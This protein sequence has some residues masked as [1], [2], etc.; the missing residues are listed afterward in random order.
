MLVACEY[1]ACDAVSQ[2][3]HVSVE[4]P[5]RHLEG[6]I[7]ELGTWEETA[8]Y[9][10]DHRVV[11]DYFLDANQYPDDSILAKRLYRLMQNPHI[12]SLYMEVDEY[13][14]D[15][16]QKVV[17]ELEGG[18]RFIKYHYPETRDPRVETIITG[19]YN[20]L[21]VSDSLIVVGLDFFMGMNGKYPPNDVP[22]YIVQ[23]YMK[24][25][26]APIILSFVSNEYNHIDQSHGTLLADMI[27][28]G[29]SY[30]FVSSALPCKPDSLIIGYTAEEM[31]LVEANQEVI[32]AN[33]IENELL[34]ETDHFLKNKFVGESPNVYEI[35]EKCPGRV[36]AWVGWQIVRKYMENNPDVTLQELMKETDGHKIFQKSGY[37]P[38]NVEP[39]PS[40]I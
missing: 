23:R 36:G 10:G 7:S 37:K 22:A 31:T 28:V 1:N 24:E 35:S 15:F 17:A 32:W 30:Y 12:D 5:V 8:S 29:K 38:K 11:A 19:Q 3:D 13:F 16:D 40:L 9:L 26:V 18:F 6:E 27:N 33:L 2:Y 20:D 14:V 4:I 25:S 21:Y 39:L 34:Y